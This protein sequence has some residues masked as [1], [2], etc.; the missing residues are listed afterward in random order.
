MLTLCVQMYLLHHKRIN[1]DQAM[2]QSTKHS[3]LP[4]CFYTNCDNIVVTQFR[5]QVAKNKLH[6]RTERSH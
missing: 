5:K 1:N 3:V 6:G 2:D 4:S